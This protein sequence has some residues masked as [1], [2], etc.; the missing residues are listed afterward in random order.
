MMFCPKHVARPVLGRCA[1]CEAL[2]QHQHRRDSWVWRTLF[3]LSYALMWPFRVWPLWIHDALQY[4]NSRIGYR[5]VVPATVTLI[6]AYFGLYAVMEARH[7]RRRNHAAFERSAFTDL[8]TSNDRGAFIAA[9]KNFG[10][11]QMM[12]VPPEPQLWP[13]WKFL[14]WWEKSS[15]PNRRQ[16]Y[17]WSQ[18]FLSRCT[19][20]L[21]GRP[22]IN[23]PENPDKGI[24]IDLSGADLRG[25][26][27]A[28]AD[29][30]RADLSW[31]DLRGAY[32]AGAKLREVDLGGADL[33]GVDFRG[34]PP[35]PISV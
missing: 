27:L 32:L 29:L 25:A 3:H 31:A 28:G 7:E 23:D 2:R 20:Q 18:S 35:P 17:T 21:C 15:Q 30:S 24:R 12:K 33:R 16:L 6:A 10:P 26:D 8:V 14:S 5:V 13:P 19:P 34:F 4:L 22:D 1:N 11:I 9:M